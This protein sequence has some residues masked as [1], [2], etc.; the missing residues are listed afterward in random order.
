M[1]TVKTILNKIEF[2]SEESLEDLVEEKFFNEDIYRK[3]KKRLIY[4]I[5]LARIEEIF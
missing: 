3:I 1:D 2:K 5:A 4:E